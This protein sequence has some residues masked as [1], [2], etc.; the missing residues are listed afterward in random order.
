MKINSTSQKTIF[1]SYKMEPKNTK[2]VFA[3]PV[4]KIDFGYKS[5]SGENDL[6]WDTF[7]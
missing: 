1:A 7:M 4:T 6:S 5:I 3:S 2:Q